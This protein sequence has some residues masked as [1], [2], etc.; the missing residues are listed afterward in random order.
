MNRF[1][2]IWSKTAL[3]LAL[4]SISSSAFSA[5][6]QGP[7]AY[8]ALGDSIC[9]GLWATPGFS[10]VTQYRGFLATDNGLTVNL[11]NQGVN[12]WTSGDLLNAMQTNAS[13]RTAVM[14]SQVITWD[15]GGNDMIDARNTYKAATCGGADN[16]NCLRTAV[17]TFRTNWNAILVQI[18]TLRANS[19]VILRTMD[20]Y[21][22]Y[23]AT[24]RSSDTW[25]N[26]GGLNDFLAFKPYID[27]INNFIR[28]TSAAR[29]VPY[30]KVYNAFNGA[31]GDQDAGGRGYISAFDGLHPNTAGHGVIANQFRAATQVTRP[32]RVG[33]NFDF[34]GDGR[35]ELAVFRPSSG[36][37]YLIDSGAGTFRALSFGLA[38]DRV[39]AGDYDGDGKS[40]IAMFRPSTGGWYI[41]NSGDGLFRSVQFG[42]AGDIPVP[43]DYDGDARTDIAVYRGGAWYWLRSS[44]GTFVA[45]AFG[46]A[47]DKP[48]PGDFDGDGRSDLVV[49]RPANGTWYQLLSSNGVFRAVQFGATGDL[50]VA[51]DLD[52]DLKAD[53]AVFRP[54]SGSWYSLQSSSGAFA[55]VQ[56]GANGD[57]PIPA[58]YDGDGRTDRAVFRP[59]DGNWYILNSGNGSFRASNFGLN[60]DTPAPAALN[61]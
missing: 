10:Y 36:S 21:N 43:G 58:E 7:W 47:A 52:G 25:A 15:I 42:L 30:A 20:V 38:G 6:G 29:G 14:G 22:P 40:D 4:I 45:R 34:D 11:N 41:L 35:T 23:I 26:D 48:N 54:A 57:L 17:A 37:W 53:I 49:F 55:G 19:Q 16:Q 50:P 27:D 33:E 56:F 3:W 8:T 5:F 60:G 1:P 61:Q 9:F 39:V 44:D 12:G 32:A 28:V 59:S 46:A 2:R 13:L 31:N 24:D 18:F 51:A